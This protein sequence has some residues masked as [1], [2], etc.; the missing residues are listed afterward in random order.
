MNML[1]LTITG[2]PPCTVCGQP[3][4]VWDY[5]TSV[6]SGSLHTPLRATY[7]ETHRPSWMPRYTLLA[8]GTYQQM[9]A[10]LAAL[11]EIVETVFAHPMVSDVRAC[12]S[13]G[14]P[15]VHMEHL[16]IERAKEIEA[17]ARVLL[18]QET[19]RDP[20]D[21]EE[22]DTSSDHVEMNGETGEMHE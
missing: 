12:R 8:E 17:K 16:K 2:G 22:E 5:D 6:A 4:T 3:S 11:R 13:C 18:H 10:E 15:V 9:Q 1:N 20:D 14:V 21:E 7:C 19:W